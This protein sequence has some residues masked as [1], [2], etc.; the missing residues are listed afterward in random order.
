MIAR[1][2]FFETTPSSNSSLRELASASQLQTLRNRKTSA[3]IQRPRDTEPETLVPVLRGKPRREAERRFSGMPA[4]EPPRTTRLPPY[5]RLSPQQLPFPRIY[6]S[7]AVGRRTV[8][9]LVVVAKLRPLPDVAV[10][11][12]EAPWIRRK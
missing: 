10:H 4:Q 5:S 9:V 11:L 1:M 3:Y 7:R 8:V 6:P 12:I 2:W